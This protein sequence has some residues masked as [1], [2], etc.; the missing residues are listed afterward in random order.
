[1]GAPAL[2]SFIFFAIF[3]NMGINLALGKG[4]PISEI[5]NITSDVSTAFFT[6]M[7]NYNFGFVISIV[8]IVL[9]ITFFITSA[10]SATFVLGMFTSQGNLN[11]TNKKKIMLGLLQSFLAVVLL[12]TGGLNALQTSSLVAAFPFI[13]IMILATISLT[14][15]L[16][17]E[18]IIK[19]KIKEKSK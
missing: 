12:L 1:M 3:G 13:F 16:K 7:S 6:V 15:E 10:N 17:N 9:L 19:A 5:Q 14:K 2:A 4:M 18:K 8:T 11:P